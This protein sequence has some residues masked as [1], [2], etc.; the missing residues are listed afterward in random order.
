MRELVEFTL[1]APTHYHAG[2]IAGGEVV[3][4]PEQLHA[5]QISDHAAVCATLVTRQRAPEYA[6]PI[7]REIFRSQEFCWY[8]HRALAAAEYD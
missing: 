7:P 1:E 8:M 6:W 3:G 5:K 4:L 2:A